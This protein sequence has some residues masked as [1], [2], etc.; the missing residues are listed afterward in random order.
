VD[1]R[2]VHRKSPA[3]HCVTVENRRW[4]VWDGVRMM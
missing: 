3:R 2:K 1:S 4:P